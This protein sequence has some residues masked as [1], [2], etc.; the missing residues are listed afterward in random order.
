MA[1]SLRSALDGI[2]VADEIAIDNIKSVIEQLET[3][4]WTET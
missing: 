4:N 2:S 3:R 1:G